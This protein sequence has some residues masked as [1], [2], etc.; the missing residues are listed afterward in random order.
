MYFTTMLTEYPMAFTVVITGF[1]PNQEV[2]RK[3]KMGFEEYTWSIFGAASREEFGLNCL[4]IC[5]I[6]DRIV[7][8]INR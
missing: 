4:C 8:R 1:W 5:N 2:G 3:V 7:F 6:V